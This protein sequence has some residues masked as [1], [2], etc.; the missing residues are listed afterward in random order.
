MPC[1]LEDDA[2]NL[3]AAEAL[4]PGLAIASG[5]AARI[6]ERGEQAAFITGG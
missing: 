3:Q 6:R 5:G 1:V 4:V 2:L